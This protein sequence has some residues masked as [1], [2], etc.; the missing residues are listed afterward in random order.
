L[1][2]LRGDDFIVSLGSKNWGKDSDGHNVGSRLQQAGTF[3]HELG[4]NLGL[5]HGGSNDINHK[6]NYLSVMNY[7]FVMP[8]LMGIKTLDYSRCKSTNLFEMSLSEEIG[9]NFNCPREEQYPTIIRSMEQPGIP[10]IVKS[11]IP[12]DYNGDGDTI[13]E[14]ITRDLN[15]DMHPVPPDY[16]KSDNS[17]MGTNDANELRYSMLIGNDDWS[18]LKFKDYRVTPASGSSGPEYS[19]EHLIND[20]LLLLRGIEN[21]IKKIAPT[22]FNGQESAIQTRNASATEISTTI[23]DISAILKTDNLDSAINKISGL[24]N[25]LKTLP[26]LGG[27]NNFTSQQ[28]QQQEL[29]FLLDNLITV[30]KQQ[31]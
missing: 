9:I 7:L 11:G 20:R 21:Q 26:G 24:K 15:W 23:K 22:A 6:P 30:L 28:S 5:H 31:K 3:M 29:T 18:K 8:S 13:D 14:G 2:E 4:H 16:S 17:F 10:F 12:I 27:I 19:A 1:G 25:K